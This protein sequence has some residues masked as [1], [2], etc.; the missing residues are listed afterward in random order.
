VVRLEL[1][2]RQILMLLAIPVTLWILVQIWPVVLL[3]LVS[4]IFAA[5]LL[6]LVGW[7]VDRGVGRGLAVLVVLVTL[8]LTAAVIGFVVIP[9]VV[10][11]VRALIDLVP[12]LRDRL[13]VFLNEHHAYRAAR[14]VQQFSPGE[15]VQPELLVTTGREVLTVVATIAT[16]AVLTAYLMYDAPRIE[17]FIYFATPRAYHHH[18]HNLLQALQRVVGGYV[19]GE[20]LTSAVLSGF[21]FVILEALR[22]PNPVAL[23]VFASIAD[24]VPVIGI[25]L[26][27]GPIVAAALS[28]SVTKAV[29]AAVLLVIYEEFENR[30]LVERVYGETLRLPT[31]VVLLALLVGGALLGVAGALLSL[32]TAAAVRVFVEYGNAV[33][34]GRVPA[35]VPPERVMAA[36]GDKRS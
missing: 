24:V 27:I 25:F 35:A 3:V 4:L 22:I 12:D 7:L 16:I 14:E 17:R 36:D 20:V 18:I 32:P 6:P 13:V 23:A 29:I 28:V 2:F 30:F 33:R 5:A 19:R 11:Q 26:I 21:T 10:G 15:L 31:V 1:S 8:L 34:E 9:V